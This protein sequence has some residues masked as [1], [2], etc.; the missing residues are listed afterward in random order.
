MRAFRRTGESV[1]TTPP[2]GAVE[3]PAT[4]RFPPAPPRNL[5]TVTIPG[6]IEMS[7]SPNAESDLA[8]YN[9]YR[10]EGGAFRKLSQELLRISLFRDTAVIAGIRRANQ[11]AAKIAV[12]AAKP[13]QPGAA[14][15][16]STR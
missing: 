11:T 4:D 13:T 12:A 2:S 16:N 1:A 3:V 15:R 6:A 7:W 14:I 10:G 5:R 8:G 9:V